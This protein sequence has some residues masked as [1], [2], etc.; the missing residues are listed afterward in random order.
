MD[1]IDRLES[2]QG[3]RV[4][5]VASTGGH[6]SQVQSW[7]RRLRFASDSELVTFE[8]AQSK[9][10]LGYGGTTF[11]DYVA[12]RDFR[13]VGRAAKAIQAHMRMQE[14]DVVFSTGAGVALAA[15]WVA[16][17]AGLPFVY[18][19]SVSRFDAP[20]VTGR[21]LERMPRAALFTQHRGYGKRWREAGSLLEGP[22]PAVRTALPK[23]RGIRWFVTLGT[24]R[25]YRFDRMIDKVL[26]LLSAGDEVRWQVGC[27]SR[28]D[29][30]GVVHSE[31]RVDEF[32]DA[33]E[34]ADVV[35]T[36]AGV[37]TVMKLLEMGVEPIVAERSPGYDE[38]V[39]G[40]QSEIV[41]FLCSRSLALNL[42]KIS[43]V[44][45]LRREVG[46]ASPGGS[47]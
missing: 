7:C 43:S 26:G 15:W 23:N 5:A 45:D 21:L 35:V 3:K 46:A 2:L 37:G 12:P 1:R 38:H 18:V 13:G 32:D 24:I 16:F 36:H 6:L 10:V 33:V 22:F 29:L 42:F 41:D 31:M 8:N 39:D 17:R 34:W 20:S 14:F 9:G 19:E 27:S 11:V 47:R 30:P 40:H 25:P 4:L 44:A 28:D